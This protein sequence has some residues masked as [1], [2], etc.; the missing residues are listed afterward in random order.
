[1]WLSIVVNV[2]VRLKARSVHGMVNGAGK[3][4]C[5]GR[6]KPRFG[7]N[8]TRLKFGEFKGYF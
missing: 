4:R 8:I 1:M 3:E 2:S 7:F 6:D 5:F